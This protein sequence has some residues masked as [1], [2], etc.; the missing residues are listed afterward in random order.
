[1]RDASFTRYWSSMGYSPYEIFVLLH[2]RK[3]VG[4]RG[5][6]RKPRLGGR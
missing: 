1:M 4:I 5:I 3:S 6:S 2:S